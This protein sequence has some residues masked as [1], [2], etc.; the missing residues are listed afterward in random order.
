MGNL[1]IGILGWRKESLAQTMPSVVSAFPGARLIICHRKE[2]AGAIRKMCGMSGAGGAVLFSPAEFGAALFAPALEGELP[3]GRKRNLLQLASHSLSPGAGLILLDDDIFP[4]AATAEAF[5]RSFKK[6]D[7]VQGRYRGSADNKIYALVHFFEILESGPGTPDFQERVRLGLRGEVQKPKSSP[8]LSSP[9]GGLLGISPRLLLRNCFAPTAFM[10]DDHF[11]EF[12][13]RF[14]FRELSFMGDGTADGEIPA[15][16][17]RT[18]PGAKTKLVDDYVLYVKGALVETYF[19]FRLA[20]AIP[21]VAGGKHVLIRAPSFDAKAHLKRIISE[22]A[23]EKFQRASRHYLE[24]AADG[25]LAE[26]LERLAALS[27]ADFFVGEESLGEKW[28][29]FENERAWL[30]NASVKT[31]GD[32]GSALE[33]LERL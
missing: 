1:H 4:D 30:A 5:G 23:L 6:Y 25:E 7:L 32:A 19:Y 27:E 3:V 10:F 21:V 18:I 16:T 14:S 9:P 8:G 33:N 17:H 13:S 2:D 28:A 15:A 20:G 26:E 29:S 24:G 31:R 12:S 11:F 22:A